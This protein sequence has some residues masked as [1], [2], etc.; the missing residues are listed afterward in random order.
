MRDC[1]GGIQDIIKK[2]VSTVIGKQLK[3]VLDGF[4][5]VENVT[6]KFNDMVKQF[7]LETQNNLREVYDKTKVNFNAP[8]A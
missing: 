4:K 2:I 1:N 5:I 3:A 8:T 7:K 6:G